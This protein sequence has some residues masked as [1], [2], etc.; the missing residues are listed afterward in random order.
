MHDD[1]RMVIASPMTTGSRSAGF[2]VP[3]TFQGKS[4]LILPD[5]IR[6]LDKSRLAKK[7]GVIHGAQCGELELTSACATPAWIATACGLAM[8]K[9]AVW[10]NPAP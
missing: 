7:V 9:L 4:D 6:T 3:V 1:L 2:R 5:Q 10:D 8:T